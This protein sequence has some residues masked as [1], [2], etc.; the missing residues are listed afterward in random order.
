MIDLSYLT[1]EIWPLARL[2]QC[3]R[4]AEQVLM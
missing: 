2:L 4:T 1:I 3:S